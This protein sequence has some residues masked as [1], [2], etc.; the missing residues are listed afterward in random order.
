MKVLLDLEFQD[1]HLQARLLVLG[2]NGR[3]W[4][5]TSLQWTAADI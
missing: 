4:C 3:D 2:A 1:H 5:Y